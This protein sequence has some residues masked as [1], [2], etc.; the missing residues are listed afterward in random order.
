ME[1]QGNEPVLLTKQYKD[2]TVPNAVTKLDYESLPFNAYSVHSQ[3]IRNLDIT[4]QVLQKGTETVIET[5][6]GRCLSGNVRVESGSLIRRTASLEVAFDPNFFPSSD[7]LV[8]FDKLYRVYV[9]IKDLS[10]TDHTVNFLLGTFNVSDGGLSVSESQSTMTVKLEDKMGQ[11]EGNEFEN[12]LKILPGTPIDEAIKLVMEDIGEKSFG[13][14]QASEEKEVVPYTMEFG[15]GDEKIDV[16]EKLRDMYMDYTCGYNPMGE[17]EF[18]KLSIQKDTEFRTPKWAFNDEAKDGKDLTIS[19]QESYPLKS[20]RNRV[21]VVGEMSEKTGITANGEI[22]ITDVK[23]PFNVDAIGTR[24]KIIKESSYVTDDQC[25]SRA[26]YEVWKVS[27][28]QE[29]CDISVVPIYLFDVNDIIEI[30]HPVTG[31]VSKYLI[32]DFSIDL[33]VDG[34]MSI[35]AHRIYYTGVEYG[36]AFQPLVQKFVRGISNY[37][38]ISLAEERI[39]D[40][41]NITG[42]GNATITVRFVELTSGGEQASITSYATTKNQTLQID[43]A[44][45]KNLDDSENGDSGRGAADYADRVIGHEMFH[46]VTNDYLG[47]DSMIEVPLWFK[48]GFAEF[49]HGGKDRYTMVYPKT[50]SI[51]KKQQIIDLATRQLDGE[52]QGTSED[53]VAA[54]LIAIAIYN[55]SDRKTW[56]NLF[57]K[58]RGVKNIGINFLYKLLPIADSNDN[59]KEK[60]ITEIRNMDWVWEL[61]ENK[62]D[63]DTLSVGGKHFM[64][65]YN[66]ELTAETVFNNSNAT[67]ESIGF[68]IKKEI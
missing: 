67:I 2:H 24:T 6:S 68:N 52:F 20:V 43:L 55:L 4:I 45:F 15:I 17:F 9:G 47:H 65:L 7:S 37:G 39:K 8:W 35:S 60:V 21:L 5:V 18:Y 27:N 63:L 16:V 32:D 33:K 54:Y 66:T 14:I 31:T 10:M 11:F 36:E 49:L 44:D 29:K 22:R 38:W 3:P 61:L 13:Y 26:K 57:I 34:D 28:W 46:A 40:C 59:V 42:S 58:L 53:Y 41:Y 19:F 12:Q 30:K 50:D 62:N 25:Y 56:E 48:E 23:N 1:I 64:N 51:K